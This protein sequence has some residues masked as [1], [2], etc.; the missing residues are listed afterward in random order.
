MHKRRGAGGDGVA[1]R[2]SR[3]SR[4][5]RDRHADRG[6]GA[7]RGT[8]ADVNTHADADGDAHADSDAHRYAHAD[9]DAHRYAYAKAH[10][11]PEAHSDR[12]AMP[13]TSTDRRPRADGDSRR[14]AAS[15]SGRWQPAIREIATDREELGRVTFEPGDEMELTLCDAAGLF[16][17]D[18]QTGSV[19][20]WTW[21][22]RPCLRRATGTCICPRMRRRCCTT[23]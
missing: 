22:S 19:E 21:E 4:A 14:E 17:L 6:S 10:G 13:R 2:A 15:E 18:V 8:R 5:S 23:G 16:F 11:H 1:D 3:A 12:D 9:S 7:D 20:G